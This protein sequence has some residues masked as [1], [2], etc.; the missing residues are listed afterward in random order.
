MILEFPEPSTDLK[1]RSFQLRKN[2]FCMLN[3]EHPIAHQSSITFF[4][5]TLYIDNTFRTCGKDSPDKKTRARII[6][7][8]ITVNEI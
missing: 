8:T 6:Y 5:Y 7:I 3:I 1:A 4:L 2:Y